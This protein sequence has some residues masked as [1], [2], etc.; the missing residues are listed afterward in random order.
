MSETAPATSYVYQHG[1]SLMHPEEMYDGEQ[2]SRKAMK[3][4]SV[5]SDYLTAQGQDP[6][7]LSLLDIGCS[8]GFLTQ[9]YGTLF[10]QVTGI[11]IDEAGV[12]YAADNNKNPNVSFLV[13]DSMALRFEDDSFDCVTCTHIYEH[14]P[15]APRLMA[16]IF[17]VLKPGGH[18]YFAA[19]N[20]FMVMEPHYRLPLLSVIPKALAHLYIRWAGK[21]DHYYETLL[22]LRGLRRLVRDFEVTDYT[23]RIVADPKRF[24]ATDMLAPGSLKQRLSLLIMKAAYWLCPTYIWILRKPERA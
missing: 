9:V 20:R 12:G 16:E 19:G 10:G 11:D 21:A 14:V 3:T 8:T 1:F 18:C 15:D 7:E 4:L 17:R 22:S 6:S 24:H 2:R 23:A 13:A 5:L